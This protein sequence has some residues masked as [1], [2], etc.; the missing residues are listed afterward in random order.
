MLFATTELAARIERA[1]CLLLTDYADA[2][3]RNVTEVEVLVVPI[4]GG[5]GVYGGPGAPINR[6]AGLGFDPGTTRTAF[7]E[8]LEGIE[9]AW[10]ERSTPVHVELSCLADP[11]IGAALTERGYVLRGFEN[12]LGCSLPRE[13]PQSRPALEKIEIGVSPR[14]Q[15][16]EWIDAV[17]TG[18][19]TPDTQGIPSHESYPREA[20]ERGVRSTADAAGFTRFVARRNG[21][22]AGGA[23]L[24]TCDGV[25]HMCGA[26]TLPGHR[27]RGVQGALFEAR[28]EAAARDGCDLA[29]VTT[30]PG[31]K[32][33]ENAQR[34][35]FDLLYTR[36]VLVREAG[37]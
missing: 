8:Q 35:G 2:I 24:R 25:A 6:V 4:G 9:R 12:I 27:R 21:A 32:S 14:E 15:L 3:R 16:S 30:L 29:V 17:V 11:S 1:E 10:A 36:A 31:S 22:I 37:R 19:A 20:I 5:V 28:L 7:A 13:V 26:A 33:Q 18:F 23:T 34:R